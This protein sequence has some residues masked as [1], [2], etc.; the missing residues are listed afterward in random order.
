MRKNSGITLI[1][2]IITIIILIILAGV[3]I[4]LIFGDSGIIDRVK[5]ASEEYKK[6]QALEELTLKILEVKINTEGNATLS[7]VVEALNNDKNNEYIILL[8][9]IA[10]IRGE[11]PN[12]SNVS[13]IYVIYKGYE[14]EINENLEVS[15]HGD[16]NVPPIE[17]NKVSVIY[18]GN[19]GV[20]SNSNTKIIKK[21]KENTS[22]ILPENTFD[23]EMYYFVSWV[24]SDGNEYLPGNTYNLEKED[25]E[26]FAK[27]EYKIKEE[28]AFLVTNGNQYVYTGII[29]NQ[30]TS[31][32]MQY[33]LL[34]Q[35]AQILYGN[36]EGI[37]KQSFLYSY[38]NEGEQNAGN[39]F[40]YANGQKHVTNNHNGIHK[41]KQDKNKCYFNDQLLYTYEY[42]NFTTPNINQTSMTLFNANTNGNISNEYGA[43]IKFYYCKIWDNGVLVRDYI[44]VL[45]YKDI[46]CLYDKVNNKLY[47]PELLQ[48]DKGGFIKDNGEYVELRNIYTNGNQIIDTGY[49]SNQ[50]TKVEMKYI[51]NK[52]ESQFL[53]GSRTDV[54]EKTFGFVYLTDNN[55]RFDYNNTQTPYTGMTVGNVYTVK[56]DKNKF[57]INNTLKG[58]AQYNSFVGEYNMYLFGMNTKETASSKASVKF[59][60]FKIWDN[61][62]LVRDYIPVLRNSDNT[63]CLYDKV[64][65]EYYYSQGTAF[66]LGK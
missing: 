34:S 66:T 31:L 33:E 3:S 59:Y 61:D 22:I 16:V 57:Y 65:N 58:N 13:K 64:N 44:P 60:Y 54:K 4:N 62:V 30:D 19:G 7:D 50:D 63:I 40:D 17:E 49:K 20:L 10:T 36:R 2:L 28:L 14:F 6:N 5:E 37:S 53:Y 25:I 23:K 56:Q 26:F 15:I 39:R 43:E 9:K 42:T 8:E 41:I 38:V 29:P 48:E 12:L 1:A 52:D 45:D 47:Y 18:N 51:L 11:I 32:E 27:W 24:D 55:I 35:K 21:E 46:V